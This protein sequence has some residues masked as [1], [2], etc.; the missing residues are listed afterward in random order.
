MED[1]IYSRHQA[2]RGDDFITIESPVDLAGA[3]RSLSKEID[4]AIIDCLTVWIGNLMYRFGEDRREFDQVDE[5]LAVLKDPP[6]DL[7]IVTN[8]IGMGIIPDNPLSRIFRDN[9]G[10]LNQKVANW[11]AR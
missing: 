3:I 5:F 1:R 9:A 11:P 10:F 6:C 7:I 2:E 8:E 4:A